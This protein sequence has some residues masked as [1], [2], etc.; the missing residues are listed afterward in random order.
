MESR[1]EDGNAVGRDLTPTKDEFA[2]AE[3]FASW[4]R[5][6]R[7]RCRWQAAKS[8]PPHEYTIREWRPEAS[9]EFERAATGIRQFGYSQ[10]FY[11]STYIYFDLD[12]L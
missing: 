1:N 3:E 11:R 2:D 7:D 10:N 8:V 12:E 9:G 5:S 4:F 6:H